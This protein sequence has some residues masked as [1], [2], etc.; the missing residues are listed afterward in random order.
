LRLVVHGDAALLQIVALSLQVSFAAVL[1]AALVGLPFG[2]LLAVARF[3]GRGAL[4][5]ATNALM[6]LPPVVAGLLIYLLL[7]RSGPLGAFGLLFTPTAMVIAQAVLVAP[8]LAALSRQ[9][10]EA[11]WD[12][13]AEQLHSF[14]VSAAQAVPTLLWDGRLALLTV[15][16]AGFG[17]ASAEVGAVMIVGGNIDGFTRMMTTTIALE[18]SKGD[19]PLALA[20]GAVLMV[21]V[22]GVN[23]VAQ[24]VRGASARWAG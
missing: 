9:M 12:E 15:L 5:I 20:L 17:R 19:L 16:L 18:T 22:L 24:V 7:S 14:R 21:I 11:M 23:A 10:L 8:I 2:A 6:G 3:P 1:A 4:V 13:Y